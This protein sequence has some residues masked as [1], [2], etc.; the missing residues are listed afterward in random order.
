MGHVSCYVMLAH[1]LPSQFQRMLS[2]TSLRLL[3]DIMDD[4]CSLAHKWHGA[5]HMQLCAL[6]TCLRRGGLLNDCC[7]TNKVSCGVQTSPVLA[8]R[9]Y[10]DGQLAVRGSVGTRL[11]TYL[12][13]PV[14]HVYCP[15]ASA[16]VLCHVALHHCCTVVTSATQ[17]SRAD[18]LPTQLGMLSCLPTLHYSLC[19]ARALL[20]TGSCTQT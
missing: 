3:K 20:Q 2:L 16:W 5:C 9:S 14:E 7:S 18:L 19:T 15:A 6:V 10:T 11:V 8:C 4:I 12:V 17:N 1:D 13:Y